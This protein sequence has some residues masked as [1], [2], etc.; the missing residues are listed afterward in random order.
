MIH[1]GSHSCHGILIRFD[2]ALK[3]RRAHTAACFAESVVDLPDS[4]A[5]KK[6]SQERAS[7][8]N[9]QEDW[10]EHHCQHFSRTVSIVTLQKDCHST[11]PTLT[12]NMIEIEDVTDAETTPIQQEKR[13]EAPTVFRDDEAQASEEAVTPS[14]TS[15]QTDAKE[16]GAT[17]GDLAVNDEADLKAC[18]YTCKV[19]V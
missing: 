19:V 1:S 13:Q 9:R 12:P 16:Q 4:A 18:L 10:Q 15:P 5:K 11:S 3:A 8:R 2:V 6:A 17:A 7:E 14:V